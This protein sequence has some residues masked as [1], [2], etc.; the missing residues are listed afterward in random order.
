MVALSVTEDMDTRPG[1]VNVKCML[2]PG[3]RLVGWM[4][5]GL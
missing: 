2:D 1:G 5:V 4:G 3:D